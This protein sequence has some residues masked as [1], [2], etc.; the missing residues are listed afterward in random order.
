LLRLSSAKD[1]AVSPF[2]LGLRRWYLKALSDDLISMVSEH[3]TRWPQNLVEKR[4]SSLMNPEDQRLN[5]VE[6]VKNQLAGGVLAKLPELLGTNQTTANTAVN[7]AVPTLLAALGSTASSRDGARNIQSTLDSFDT[8]ALDNIPQSL[9]GGSTSLLNLGT[10]LLGSLFGSG[11]VSSLSGILSRFAGMDSGKSSSLLSLLAPIVLGVLKNRTQGMGADGLARLLEEQKP[12]IVNAMPSGLSSAL[13]GVQGMGG[14]ADWAR[15]TVGSA[16]QGGRV[17]VSETAGTA[18]ASA[19]A[20]ASALRWILPLLAVVIVAALLWWWNSSMRVP[21][22]TATATLLTNLTGQVNDF[23]LSATN[24][25]TGIKDA[26]SAEMAVPK[27]RELSTRLDTMRVAMD[28]LPADA[29]NRLVALVKDSS[30]K[31]MPAMDSVMA[32]PAVGDTI[33]PLIDELRR[34]LNGMVTV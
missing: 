1:V 30:A 27:L 13:G 25:F 16:Y 26:A 22:Q 33:K 8:R 6:L 18:R 21:E 2:V 15:S 19:A 4:R 24:T 31:L 3:T 11:M 5:L 20:G 7:A 10:S 34:K 17:A 9:S 23:F 12:N 29:R 14:I 28:Q 32:M